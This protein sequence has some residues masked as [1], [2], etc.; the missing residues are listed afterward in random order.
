MRAS[1]AAV[2]AAI[3]L[4]VIALPAQAAP[5][6][7]LPALTRVASRLTGLP[8]KRKVKVVQLS[9]K[10][11]DARA[12]RLLD[13]DYPPDQQAYDETLYRALG[14]LQ[15]GRPLRPLLVELYARGVRGLYDPLAHV[16]YV[17]RGASAE[18]LLREVVH[19]LQDQAFD[20]RR[21]SS[22][23][24]TTRDAALAAAAAVDG[25]AA[26]AAA[27]LGGSVLVLRTPAA[28]DGERAR[29]FLELEQKF[30]AA[31]GLRFA[32]T[33]HNLGG[34]RAVNS[35][36]RRFP[37]STEQ[38]FHVDAFLTRERPATVAFPDRAG[39][40]ER[41]RSDTFGELDLR[42]LLAIYQVPRLDHVAEGWSGG[43]T[44]LYRD[45]S[46]AEAVVLGLYWDSE[47]DAAQWREAV[48]TFVNE[49]FDPDEPGFPPPTLC[50]ADL[51]WNVGGR[52]IAF[53]RHGSRTVLVFGPSVPAAAAIAASTS[54]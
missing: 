12:L 40:F 48:T 5:P 43:R 51:C 31:V 35:A 47:L 46:G 15:P 26:L 49:A 30:P 1:R 8:A 52:A 16:V 27:L 39:G 41:V 22:L 11:I 50:G 23:R 13:R 18:V 33:L 38:V 2:L 14:L 45:A 53:S 20:L 10:A 28:Q 37:E 9:G 32:A 34:N 4:V 19:A 17:R 36:L 44:A 54:T 42:A 24:R 3:A 21:L 25:Q 6:L 7:Q 29:E